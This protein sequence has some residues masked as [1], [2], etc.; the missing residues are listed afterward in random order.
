MVVI[1][2]PTQATTL[3]TRGGE[4]IAVPSFGSVARSAREM[5]T[6]EP[7]VLQFTQPFG[8]GDVGALTGPYLMEASHR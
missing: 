6:G 1:T 7:V 2:A 3:M 8:E 5:V 4:A